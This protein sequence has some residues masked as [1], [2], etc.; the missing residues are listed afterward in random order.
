MSR[1]SSHAA[2][3]MTV[4]V[5]ESVTINGRDY[6]STQNFSIASIADINRRV[7]TVTTTEAINMTFAS[8]TAGGSFIPGKVQYMRFTNLDATNF[9]TL[10]FTN[11][12]G[13]EVAIKVDAGRSFIWAADISA[14]MVDV[15]NATENADANSDA[16]LGD[17]ALVQ[18]D[19]NTGSCD[20]E[21]FIASIA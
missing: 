5:K 7:V 2:A 19:A 16:A 15:M 8:A 6:G 1:I 10:T 13:D 9:L 3:T 12:D 21:I 17:L 20:L 4:T 18:A 14:G 11:E